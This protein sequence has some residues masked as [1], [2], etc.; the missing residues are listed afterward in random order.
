[1]L[2]KIILF[3][4]KRIEKKIIRQADILLF[5]SQT[6]KREII[7]SFCLDENSMHLKVINNGIKFINNTGNTKYL[8]K[9]NF[10][11]SFIGTLYNDHNIELFLDALNDLLV[12]YKCEKIKVYFVGSMLNCP[13]KHKFKI[14]ELKK[15]IIIILIS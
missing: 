10:N 3:N 11:I 13:D 2:Q 8:S 4:E 6:L 1:M 14:K 12:K 7:K 15:N 5:T 9:K